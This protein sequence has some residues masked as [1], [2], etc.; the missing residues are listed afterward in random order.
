MSKMKSPIMKKFF[1]TLT[2]LLI[3]SF[4]F[5]QT[6]KLTVSFKFLHIVEGYDHQCKSVVYIDGKEVGESSETAESAGTTFTVDVPNGSHDVKVMNFALYEGNWEEHTIENDYSIDCVFEES[7][8]QFTGKAQKL[9]LMHD[10]DAKTYYSWKKALKT[11]KKTG[12]V[13][14]PKGQQ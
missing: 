2:L 9:F 8:H 7:G 10:I 6:T 5:S 1:A 3:A 11:D 4:G 13:K 12:G 14:A